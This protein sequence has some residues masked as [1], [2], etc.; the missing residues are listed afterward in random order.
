MLHKRWA[1]HFVWEP[2]CN[3]CTQTF[4]DIY[5]FPSICGG[6]NICTSRTGEVFGM[7]SLSS[8]EQQSSIHQTYF[9]VGVNLFLT[10]F[11]LASSESTTGAFTLIPMLPGESR[12]E[13]FG[14]IVV[15]LFD[16]SSWLLG[17]CCCVHAGC[18]MIINLNIWT[19]LINCKR[20]FDEWVRVCVDFGATHTQY[21]HL[22]Q[23]I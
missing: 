1:T 19:V 20:E 11:K 13:E 18:F 17:S 22:K 4:Y 23:Q 8:Q 16:L 2:L 10:Y 9:G 21:L 15:N 3:D 7:Q 5:S 6:L 12:D 14:R